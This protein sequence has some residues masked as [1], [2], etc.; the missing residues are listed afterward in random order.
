MPQKV[1]RHLLV[2]FL[3]GALASFLNQLPRQHGTLQTL[4]RRGFRSQ[5]H[6]AMGDGVLLQLD[7]PLNLACRAKELLVE[8]RIRTAEA[9]EIFNVHRG[10]LVA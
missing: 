5:P 2:G 9:Y 8:H 10:C 4:E 6:R 1:R 7:D 3:P